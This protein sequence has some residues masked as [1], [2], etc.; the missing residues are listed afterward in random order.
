MQIK[1][2]ILSFLVS[3]IFI[4]LAL[5]GQALGIFIGEYISVIYENWGTAAFIVSLIPYIIGGVLG[6]YISAVVA[7]KIYKNII[8]N[9]ALILP[10][11]V[12]T[13]AL[14][15]NF[16]GGFNLKESLSNFL[17]IASYFYV[18]KGKYVQ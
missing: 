8:F 7:K 5:I 17:L 6:G 9:Y 12:I 13:A 10:I 15:G 18:I 14:L 2:K 1:N 3:F 4:P 11:L 16:I